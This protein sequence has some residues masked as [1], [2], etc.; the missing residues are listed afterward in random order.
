MYLGDYYTDNITLFFDTEAVQKMAN[1]IDPYG[2]YYE[3]I[4]NSF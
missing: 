3:A 4:A 1:I 2:L